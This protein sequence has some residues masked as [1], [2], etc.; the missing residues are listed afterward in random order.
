MARE[1]KEERLAREAQARAEEK[2]RVAE[3]RKTLPRV[4]KE[5]MELADDLLVE[6]RLGLDDS[7]PLLQFEFDGNWDSTVLSYESEQWEVE[8]IREKLIAIKI[9]K[10]AKEAKKRLAQTVFDRLTSD[11]KIA[12]RECIHFC[13]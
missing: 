2:L 13:K 1:T 3:Y 9:E 11:E 5:L 6:N 7:G 8:W 12:I 10:E 4:L